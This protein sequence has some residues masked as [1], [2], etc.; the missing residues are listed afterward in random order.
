MSKDGVSSRES[1]GSAAPHRSGSRKVPRVLHGWTRG[2][3]GYVAGG[4]AGAVLAFSSGLLNERGPPRLH[5][6][7]Q[8]LI[9]GGGSGETTALLPAGTSLYFDQAFPEGFARYKVYVNV[10]GVR[11][12]SHESQEKFWLSPLSA[13]PVDG[14]Q[15]RKLLR[16]YP[17]SREDLASILEHSPVTRDEIRELLAEYE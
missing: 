13:R 17:L 9:I 14:E 8:P 7:E 15:L 4:L 12:E 5:K 16:D 3:A 1:R 10:E 6:L 2:L 11:L